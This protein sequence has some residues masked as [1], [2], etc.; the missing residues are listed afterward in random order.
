[1]EE[2]DVKAF[3]SQCV[4]YLVTS[5]GYLIL[6]LNRYIS[7]H[8][9]SSFVQ[10]RFIAQAKP[11]FLQSTENGQ[12]KVYKILLAKVISFHHSLSAL[13]VGA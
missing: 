12:I 5:F 7:F 1:M 10:C 11:Y 3:V 13:W 4:S 2:C 8:S 6:K 9:F